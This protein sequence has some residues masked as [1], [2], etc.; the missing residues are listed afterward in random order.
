MLNFY[1]GPS[2]VYPEVRNYLTDAFDEGILNTPHRGEQFVQ[3]S[4]DVVG[5]LKRRLNIPQDYHIFFTSSATECWEILIQSL[6]SH[7]SSHIFNG[8][9]GDKWYEYAKKLRPRAEGFLFEINEPMPL[10]QLA[11]SADT[12]LICFTQNETSNGTQVSPTTI[13]N[14]HNRFR[15]TL[16]AVDATS[17][18]AGLN[19]KMIKADIWFASVQKCFGLPPGLG[20]LVCSPRAIFRA[21]QMAERGHYNSLVPMYEKMLNYQTTHTPNE[22]S[23]YLLKRVLEDRP[24][25]KTIE[26]A[27][28]DRAQELYT[29]FE[30]FTD[31]NLLVENEEVR[32]RTVL[33][34]Q[35]SERLVDDIKKRAAHHNIRL[36]NGYGQ[37]ARTTFRIANFPAIQNEEYE[38]LKRFFLHYFG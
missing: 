9:F 13:L 7:R 8:S 20:I 17:S 32:S 16:I 37:W 33:A 11:I 1:P 30:Q 12:E 35:A 27:L 26:E 22:L 6:T 4:R 36:G 38:E 10:D 19:L 18:M 31:F 2:K 25:I 29:F 5:L 14:L 23:I 34:V 28:T 15:D 3:L 21:K 24:F